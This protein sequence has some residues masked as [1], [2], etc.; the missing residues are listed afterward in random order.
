MSAIE[1]F[2]FGAYTLRPATITDRILARRWTEAD[3]SH[4]HVDP[5]F[6]TEQKLGH[7]AY[8]LFDGEVGLLF[9]KLVLFEST[10]VE[11]GK[12]PIRMVEMHIQ[13]PPEEEGEAARKRQALQLMTALRH[14]FAWL[15]RVL[16]Q[17]RIHSV[18]FESTSESLIAFCVR[19]LGF[20]QRGTRL[21]KELTP[22]SVSR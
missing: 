22:Q 5:D 9:F 21:H 13:F 15:E 6:W 11:E 20:N 12:E 10:L 1:T 8:L 2:K 14:G 4:Q 7:D 18:F 3:A 16:T 17:I 19:Y